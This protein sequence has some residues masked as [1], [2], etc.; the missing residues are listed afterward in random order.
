VKYPY[1]PVEYPNYPA[2]YPYYPVWYPY[3]PVECSCRFKVVTQCIACREML[4]Q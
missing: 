1:Y 2:E 3:N 4:C